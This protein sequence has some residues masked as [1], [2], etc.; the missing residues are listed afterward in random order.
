MKVLEGKV[1]L[2]T[3]GSRGIGRAIV[4]RFAEQGAAVAFTYRK[5]E[6]EA[7]D[8]VATIEGAGGRAM[9]IQADAAD[10]D[11]AAE[12]VAKVVEQFGRLDILVNNAGITKDSL[13][14]RMSEQAWDAVIDTNL[15]SAF[16]YTHAVVPQMARQRGISEQDIQAGIRYIKSL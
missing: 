7:A 5:G 11:R 10:F 6:A 14:L 13:L 15:K 8:V 16:N 4:L 3:G 12:V 2:V 9:A 1:A